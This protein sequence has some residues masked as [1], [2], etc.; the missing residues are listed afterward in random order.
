MRGGN[1]LLVVI[2]LRHSTVWLLL[3]VLGSICTRYY[4][5]KYTGMCLD[6]ELTIPRG[7]IYYVVCVYG[8][9]VLYP[10][11][12]YYG[13]CTGVSKSLHASIG[14]CGRIYMKPLHR[15]FALCTVILIRADIWKGV[16]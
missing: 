10:Q 8:L 16:A 15:Y 3:H 2:V 5:H 9:V 4:R 7:G 6:N 1:T 12:T 14:L 13:V 11:R